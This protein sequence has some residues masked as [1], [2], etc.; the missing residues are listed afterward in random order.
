MCGIFG[1]WER[2]GGAVD[3][4]RVQQA[5]ASMRHRGPDD[6][7]YLLIDT[8]SG[9]M[10]PCAGDDTVASLGLPHIRSF[11]A[12]RFDLVLGH[13]RLA[14]LDTSSAG[15][16]PMVGE[17][18]AIV[19]SGEIYNF[20]ALRERVPRR[21][22]STSDTEV[23]LALLEA[24]D[25]H[26][27]PDERLPRLDGMWAFGMWDPAARRLLCARD[28]FGMKPLHYTDTGHRFVFASEMKA[29]LAYTGE[30]ARPHAPSVLDFLAWGMTDHHDE[31]F[32][33]GIRVLAPGGSLWVDADGARPGR[34]N[35]GH[36]VPLVAQDTPWADVVRDLL[37]GS[38]RARLRADV[39]V[40]TCLSGGID[41]SSVISLVSTARRETGGEVPATFTAVFE[42]PALDER[43]YARAVVEATGA[44]WHQ[45]TPSGA[46]LFETLPT[47]LWHQEAP[48]VSSSVY[49]QWE[50]MAA[51]KAAGVTV[52]LD[53]QGG[54]ELFAGYPQHLDRYLRR[55]LVTG[56]FGR[57]AREASAGG[58]LAAGLRRALHDPRTPPPAW[59]DPAFAGASRSP[60]VWRYPRNATLAQMLETDLRFRL[61][62]LL[63]Y[64]ERNSMAHG[65]EAR[66]PFLEDALVGWAANLP[67]AAKIHDGVQKAVLRDAM[68]GVVPDAILD[69]RDKVGFATPQRAWLLE[70]LPRV[71]A[72]VLDDVFLGSGYV[73][74][75]AIRTGMERPAGLDPD[76]VWRWV[77]MASWLEAFRG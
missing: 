23:L 52:L 10:V 36:K 67:D 4:G 60:E 15:H 70:E 2:D 21:W 54:D 65:V 75:T 8:E 28:A 16:Q 55:L 58:G 17:R 62:S 43:R 5:V 7:G 73:E 42:D 18:C 50:V 12:E 53:G 26:E 68:R 59:L 64:E 45:V 63:R 77:A 32:I 61:P 34:G 3:L 9:R 24:D 40:G 14:I 39:P 49:A 76:V 37:D 74:P 25:P 48:F 29:I 51:A 1:I 71:R 35:T 38:V 44:S 33:E 30:R 56:N 46:G 27:E 20:D 47:L 22:R 31:A 19:H 11:A 66:L 13:R 41:S 72:L 57:F 69:R 6:E